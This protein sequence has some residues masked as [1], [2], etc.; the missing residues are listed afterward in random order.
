MLTLTLDLACTPAEA[1]QIAAE[2]CG[3][4][5]YNVQEHGPG[6]GNPCLTVQSNDF[7]QLTQIA[8]DIYKEPLE[9]I[10]HLITQN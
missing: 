1:Q 10:T 9:A 4:L 5:P 3:E 6:G 2:Y 8:M 7:G